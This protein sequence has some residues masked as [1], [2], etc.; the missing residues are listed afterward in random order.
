M[1]DYDSTIGEVMVDSLADLYVRELDTPWVQVGTIGDIYNLIETSHPP[2][3]FVFSVS[4]ASLFVPMVGSGWNRGT[5][6]MDAYETSSH[7]VST[8]LGPLR[9]AMVR[10]LDDLPTATDWYLVYYGA[11]G[12]SS[13]Y[14]DVPLGTMLQSTYS[15][16]H[17]LLYARRIP[18][19]IYAGYT[20]NSDMNALTTKFSPLVYDF[21]LK[22]NSD[23]DR[24]V[25]AAKLTNCKAGRCIYASP[26]YAQHD[27]IG[28][29]SY[30]RH[31]T[32]LFTDSDTNAGGVWRHAYYNNNGLA[33]YRIL[34][35][36]SSNG[37]SYR[38][39]YARKRALPSGTGSLSGFSTNPTAGGDFKLIFRHVCANGAFFSSANDWADAKRTNPNDPTQDKFSILDEL[40][41]Y[42]LA[43]GSFE[44]K[45]IYPGYG[46]NH[47]K[48][49]SNPVTESP[50]V[51]T[52]YEE[53]DVHFAGAY[54][55]GLV[56]STSTTATFLDG[57]LGSNWFFSIGT[58][59]DYPG[60]GCSPGPS[61]DVKGYTV[62]EVELYVRIPSPT[63][64]PTAAPS[65]V[66]TSAPTVICAA[67]SGGLPCEICE[68]G[69]YTSEAN[70]GP[71]VACPVGRYSAMPGSSRCE[72]APR[73]SYV[74]LTGQS[75]P[76]LCPAGT[77]GVVEAGGSEEAACLSCGPG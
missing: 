42:R 75:L 43:D 37:H 70:S 7:Q 65:A 15:K 4:Y 16:N 19:L 25:Q 13:S 17:L 30:L 40:E 51:I 33:P 60:D 56:R 24:F 55:T 21:S 50:D 62:D 58:T 12:P 26:T 34:S 53:V 57:S 74:E 61:A 36:R 67:G 31:G 77:F 38:P 71:C 59:Y 46:M 54:W 69:E 6:L 41:S 76:T 45:L 52:G 2:T 23:H 48:Q 68:A 3:S 14:T 44:F 47:W 28:L 8:A 9:K 5:R 63:S 72:P 35:W 66:P 18:T 22:Y 73:G 10:G 20:R 27:N 29:S 11:G 64:V 1:V 32:A 49:T 39:I